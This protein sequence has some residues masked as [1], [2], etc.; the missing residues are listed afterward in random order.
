L[1]GALAVAATLMG[2]AVAPAATAAMPRTG[3]AD[4]GTPA[5]KRVLTPEERAHIKEIRRSGR[6]RG[7]TSAQIRAE[8]ESYLKS[9]KRERRVKGAFEEP[10]GTS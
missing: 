6:E 4:G 2:G 5:Q 9:L 3:V 1:V 7:L 8:V 10:L